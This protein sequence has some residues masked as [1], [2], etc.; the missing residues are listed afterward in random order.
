MGKQTRREFLKTMGLTVASAGTVWVGV[1]VGAWVAA[2][3]V[4]G[5][6]VGVTSGGTGVAVADSTVAVVL[7]ALPTHP[8]NRTR[9][10]THAAG[11]FRTDM[12]P[13]SERLAEG[14]ARRSPAMRS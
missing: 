8:L 2:G 11:H 7:A 1:G 3:A 9:A 4:P 5:A 14:Q 10:S 12:V 6:V 13:P